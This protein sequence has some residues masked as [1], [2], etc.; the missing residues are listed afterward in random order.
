MWP[1]Y[2]NACRAQVPQAEEKTVFARFDL[3]QHVGSGVDRVR[4][5]EHKELLQ[6]GDD[7]LTRSKYLWPYSAENMPAAARKRFD[8]IKHGNL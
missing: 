5:L 7:T 8:Q 6:Q 1:A 2:I 3:M 4:K